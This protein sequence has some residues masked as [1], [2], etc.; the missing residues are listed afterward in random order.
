MFASRHLFPVTVV[1]FRATDDFL[2]V[3]CRDESVYVWQMETGITLMKY[4][5]C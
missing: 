4:D 1:K 5:Q 3:G 2:I